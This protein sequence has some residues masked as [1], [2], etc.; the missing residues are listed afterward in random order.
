MEAP[1]LRCTG[2]R[3]APPA[4]AAPRGQ[5]PQQPH[6]RG[7]SATIAIAVASGQA[8]FVRSRIAVTTTTTSDLATTGAV[9]FIFMVASGISGCGVINHRRRR[10]HAA[11]TVCRN[12]RVTRLCS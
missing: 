11:G 10:P 2:Q 1:P 8:A 3:L 12:Y 6:R 4:A 7:S 9:D 5:P